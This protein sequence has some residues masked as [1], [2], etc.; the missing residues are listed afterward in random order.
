MRRVVAVFALFA[1][2]GLSGG[3]SSKPDFDDRFETAQ[4]EIE[5]RAESIDKDLATDKVGNA[6]MPTP[7]AGVH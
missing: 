2:A 5:Q 6:P 1:L 7:A 4:T 3:C